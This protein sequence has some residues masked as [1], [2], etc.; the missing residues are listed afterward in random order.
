MFID[1]LFC[2]LDPLLVTWRLETID[3]VESL[4]CYGFGTLTIDTMFWDLRE[5][6]EGG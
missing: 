3:Y 5:L 4:F 6:V 1:L 2:A